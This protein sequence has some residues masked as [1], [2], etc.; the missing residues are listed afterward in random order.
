M[1][2]IED[3]ESRIKEMVMLAERQGH[4][5]AHEHMNSEPRADGYQYRDAV[6]KGWNAALNAV[7]AH[8]P[9]HG[10]VHVLLDQ[11]KDGKFAPKLDENPGE[12][13]MREARELREQTHAAMDAE[14]HKA[15][16]QTLHLPALEL[17]ELIRKLDVR[18]GSVEKDRYE[19]A[20]LTARVH[21]LERWQHNG[22][23]PRGYQANVN[24]AGYVSGQLRDSA[25]IPDLRG[26]SLD[27]DD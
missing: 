17:R 7:R 20:T 23:P 2:L 22:E 11:M 24:P 16:G 5:K 13:K 1:E 4:D 9:G 12:R 27:R 14:I 19:Y 26:L 10:S 15:V 25:P 21:D 3:H 6:T 18:L 8:T